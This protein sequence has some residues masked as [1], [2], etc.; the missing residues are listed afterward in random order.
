MDQ[1]ADALLLAAG[2]ASPDEELSDVD[3]DGDGDGD[4]S[5]SLSDIEDKE[6]DA[7]EDANQEESDDELSNPSDDEDNESEAE[8][9]RLEESPNKVRPHQDVVLSSH[10]DTQHTPSKLHNQ[11][12]ADAQGDEDEDP[13]SDV[14]NGSI[15]DKNLLI[16]TEIDTRKR[17]RGSIM[18]GLE[19]DIGEPSRK[20]T[21]SIMGTGDDYILEEDILQEAETSHPISGNISADEAEAAQEDEAPDEADEEPIVDDE[22]H[23]AIDIPI[24]PKKRGRKK[25]KATENGV[26]HDEDTEM[27]PDAVVNGDDDARKAED[28]DA[29]DEAEAAQKNEEE[30]KLLEQI[31]LR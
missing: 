13:L 20:R 9:E 14:D 26:S 19:D 8:T 10:A 24:S 25:K 6:A 31:L 12:T 1:G 22:A 4:G 17:K 29:E 11:M 18:A 2:A 28:G 5:S 21:G 30:R 7:E 27:G 15:E 23:E 16:V 3:V